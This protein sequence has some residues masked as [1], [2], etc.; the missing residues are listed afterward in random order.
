MLDTMLFHGA[1]PRERYRVLETFYR[2]SP[3]LIARFYAGTTTWMDKARI[4]TGKPPIPV[5]RAIRVLMGARP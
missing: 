2:L 1:A 5:A 4:L 3:G